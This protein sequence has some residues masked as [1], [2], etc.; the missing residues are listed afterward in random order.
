MRDTQQR[1]ATLLLHYLLDRLLEPV[2]VL[3]V[4]EPVGNDTVA[5]M[6]PQR[7]DNAC[8]LA[9]HFGLNG[10]HA[11]EDVRQ[12][13]EIKDVVE[14]G[15]CGQHLD[16]GAL[17]EFAR[18]WH[19]LGN[20]VADFLGEAA[21][22][23]EVAEADGG[24]DLVDGSV[25]GQGAVDDVEVA[26]E[27]LWDVVAATAWLDHSGHELD[28]DDGG[29]VAG[30][31]E[32][33]EALLLDHLAGDLVGDLVAPVVDGG[34]VDVVDEDGH[35]FA[36]WW[37][38]GAAHALVDVGLDGALEH[39]RGGGR[40]EVEGFEEVMLRVVPGRSKKI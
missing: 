32:V 25:G 20:N 30:F 40:G 33:V 17:P 31:L 15:R 29:E 11:L 27:A 10:Q 38:V 18:S 16:L 7:H 22:D 28:V 24:E 4:D 6:L 21:I 39:E 34:H 26:L 35:L 9:A 8:V 36:S 23:T 3:L 5:L 37:A 14:L 13:T 2:L 12:V 19:E 1:R